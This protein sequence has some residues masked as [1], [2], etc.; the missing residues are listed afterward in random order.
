MEQDL[1]KMR[2]LLQEFV[3]K[4]EITDIFLTTESTLNI[5]NE[6][7]RIKIVKLHIEV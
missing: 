5:G 3:D 2:D 1:Y 4:Y 7:E 6:K